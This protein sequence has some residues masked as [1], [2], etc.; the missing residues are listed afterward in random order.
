MRSLFKPKYIK[1]FSSKIP[2]IITAIGLAFLI[3]FILLPFTHLGV[4]MVDDGVM[5]KPALDLVHNKMLFK[6]TF[7][8]YGPLYILLESWILKYF[9]TYL[10]SLKIWIDFMYALTGIV[11]YIISRR[12]SGKFIS[13]LFVS[14]WLLLSPVFNNNFYIWPNVVGAFFISLSFLIYVYNRSSVIT[15]RNTFYIGIFFALSTWCK[16]PFF[17]FLLI[18]T[19]Y[20]CLLYLYGKISFKK[21]LRQQLALWLG[22]FIISSVLLIWIISNGALKDFFLQEI[23]IGYIWGRIL[24]R[25]YSPISYIQQPLL[26]FWVIVPMIYFILFINS[27][28]HLYKREK[29]TGAINNLGIS[30]FG[31][32]TSAQY[33]PYPIN[34]TSHLYWALTPIFT[35]SCY[36]LYQKLFL[37]LFNRMRDG[38]YTQLNTQFY[39]LIV[40]I[41]VIS[42]T[43]EFTNRI[44]SAAYKVNTLNTLIQRPRVLTEIYTSAQN[45]AY[46]NDVYLK[47]HSYLMT[48]PRT[49]FII[50]ASSASMYT[51]FTNKS[52]NILS[53]YADFSGFTSGVYPYSAALNNYVRNNKPLILT[54]SHNI[55]RL[56]NYYILDSWKK[57]SY[58]LAAPK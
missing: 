27:I 41:L 24:G 21:L 43:H 46:Y 36:V 3:F 31:I 12:Y 48:H 4:D 15:P 10:I 25:N 30:L 11:L 42:I 32:S 29:N 22:F 14:I 18:F 13:V 47:M 34:E 55:N 37:P 45:A 17:I 5:L 1:S 8:Q 57:Y 26:Y 53:F 58:I 19:G 33:Y 23:R 44:T 56:P 7:T 28:L 6:D 52:V 2:D 38:S 9:G 49:S 16:Q 35:Y 40:I 39:L 20:Y 54:S 51:T 50:Y